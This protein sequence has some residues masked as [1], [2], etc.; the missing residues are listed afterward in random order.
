[1]T[2]YLMKKDGSL[3]IRTDAL[4]KRSDMSPYEPVAQKNEPPAEPP[5]MLTAE[6]LESLK[7][8]SGK[9]LMAHLAAERFEAFVDV[10]QS[11][12]KMVETLLNLQAA[13]EAAQEA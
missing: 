3:Y 9:K 4:A 11:K 1:M 8:S 13:Q 10:A 12:A 6:F 2:E 7:G 5:D